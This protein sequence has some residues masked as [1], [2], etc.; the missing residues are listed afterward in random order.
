MN[1]DMANRGQVLLPIARSS[2][3]TALGNPFNVPESELW[4]KEQGACFVT[5]KQNKQLRGCIGTIEAHRPLLDDVKANAQAAALRD[6]RFSPLTLSELDIT[7]IEVSILTSK[8]PLAFTSEAN[9][10]EQLQPGIDGVVIEYGRYR[11]TFLPQ[12]WEQLPSAAEFMMHLKQKA[13]LPGNFWAE[14]LRIYRY[15]VQKWA[16]A[17]SPDE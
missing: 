10:Y 6:P 1:E 4:L 5:L 13:G 15:R 14:D 3:S 8:E 9:V 16:E 2:I 11:G 17:D 12:V 7:Q